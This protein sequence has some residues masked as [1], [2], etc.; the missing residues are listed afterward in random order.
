M[1]TE[2]DT[3]KVWRYFDHKKA[4]HLIESGCLYLR[5]LDLLTDRYEGDPYEGTPT[6]NIFQEWKTASAI[7]GLEMPLGC[8]RRR[9]NGPIA[10]VGE[11]GW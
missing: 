5:R 11:W 4:K 8:R 6:F 1:T 7:V 3:A 2:T 9:E 10:A